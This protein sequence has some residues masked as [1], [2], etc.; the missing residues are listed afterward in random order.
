MTQF[1]HVTE[2]SGL[3]TLCAELADCAW[4][5]L[6]TEFIR[7]RTYWPRLCLVQIATP[8]VTACIDP[9]QIQNL[10]PLL[11]VL[12]APKRTKVLHAA[13]QDI[14][15]LTRLRGTPPPHL[16]DTQIA[17][18]FLGYGDQ[19]GYA[20]LVE[21][22]LGVRLDKSATRTDWSLRPLSPQQ[23]T[24]AANDVFYLQQIYMAMRD[25]L[26]AKGRFDWLA[27]DMNALSNAESY[28][29]HPDQAWTRIRGNTHLKPV[30]LAVLRTLA[31]WREREAASQDRPRKRILG[32]HQL[33]DLA[34]LSPRTAADLER[35]R[36]LGSDLRRRWGEQWVSLVAKTLETPPET[37][38]R[39]RT[40]STPSP[41]TEAAIDLMMTLIRHLATL[42]DLSPTLIANRAQLHELLLG[43]EEVPVARGWRNELAGRHLA[44]LLEGRIGIG[45]S[46]RSLTI[47]EL[48]R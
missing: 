38:P 29:V 30:Q 26:D 16:F 47:H 32:D 43:S 34:R 46:N 14:E 45:L 22:V 37:W 27:E 31:A 20:S 19:I 42:N 3:A 13:H 36:G 10:D 4:L 2:A 39:L 15:I 18:S 40:R 41:E 17:A 25:A 1:R 9:L 23:L 12:Y 5:A 8:T 33:V 48:T 24:Y 7:E 28:A 11:N 6:D 35:I 44:R 21:K